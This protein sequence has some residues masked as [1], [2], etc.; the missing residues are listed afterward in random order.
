MS[1]GINCL[2]T[3]DATT[4]MQIAA[5]LDALNRER[6]SIETD[7]QDKR[8]GGTGDHQSIR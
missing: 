8:A 6:R 2:L 7:M 5:K 3:D 4:A 1:L